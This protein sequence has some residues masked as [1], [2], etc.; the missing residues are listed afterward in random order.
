MMH[1]P[2]GTFWHRSLTTRSYRQRILLRVEAVG[3]PLNISRQDWGT[4]VSLD[5]KEQHLMSTHF[6]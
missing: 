2:P 1:R 5:K 3:H 6:Y 4:Y